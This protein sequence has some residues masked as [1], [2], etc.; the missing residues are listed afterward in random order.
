MLHPRARTCLKLGLLL[1]LCDAISHTFEIKVDN[2]PY[3]EQIQE[4]HNFFLK[5]TELT[6]YYLTHL[7]NKEKYKLLYIIS[8]SLFLFV[9]L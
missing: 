7:S 3:H 8:I 6:V 5:T 1:F 2:L 9:Y 4:P